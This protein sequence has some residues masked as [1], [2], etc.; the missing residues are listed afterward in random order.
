MNLAEQ[1]ARFLESRELGAF[2]DAG[3]TLFLE[4]LPPQPDA[5][6]MVRHTGGLMPDGTKLTQPTFQIVV[7]HPSLRTAVETANAVHAALRYHTDSLVEG[8]S[9]VSIVWPLQDA[10]VYIGRDENGR[11]LYSINVRLRV[12]T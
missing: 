9:E 12:I 4:N 10:P 8:E 2:S 7:R 5:A 1:I 11:H 3:G 6:I